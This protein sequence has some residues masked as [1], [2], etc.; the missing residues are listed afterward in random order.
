MPHF[1]ICY[2]PSFDKKPDMNECIFSR[3]NKKVK[4]VLKSI[5]GISILKKNKIVINGNET[6][7]SIL[8]FLKKIYNKEEYIYLYI[9]NT[10]K[11]NLDD[12][13]SDL[14]DLYQISNSLNI[15]YS[16]NPAY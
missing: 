1:P 12:Y 5:S 9:N 16:F 4:I 10:I 2:F 15:S 6:L 13:I 8:N 14:F 3:R 7:V 11:P